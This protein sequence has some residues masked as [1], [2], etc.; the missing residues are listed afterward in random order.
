MSEQD[1]QDEPTLTNE[2]A[3]TMD[4]PPREDGDEEG[5]AFN[6]EEAPSPGMENPYPKPIMPLSDE[7]KAA[8][9]GWL[10]TELNALKQS[11]SQKQDQWTRQEKAYR[12]LPEGPQT[13]PFVGANGDVVPLVASGVDPVY[14]RL[15]TGIFKS[16][17]WFRIKPLKIK[18][19]DVGP[20]LEAWVN[21][22]ARHKLHL[23]KVV[24]PRLLE[25]VKHGTCVFKTIYDR[26][27]Y[28][29]RTYDKNWKPIK[30]VVTRYSGPRVF[31]VSLSDFLVPPG[32]QDL[33]DCHIVAERQRMTYGDLQIAEKSGKLA[34]CEALKGQEDARIQ[35][36]DEARAESAQH[37]DVVQASGRIEVFEVWCRYDINED[38]VPE[39]IVATFHEPTQTLLQLRYNWLFSQ[40]Y[41]YTMIP[42]GI[43]NDSLYGIGVSEMIE[44]FQATATQWQRHALNNAYLANI[45]MFIARK[46][47]GM[48]EQPKLYSG[49]VLFVDDPSRD[50]IPFRM[51][52]IYN[53]TISER[54]NLMGLAEK[55][56]GISDY[57]TGRE[58]PIVGS[59]ATATSTVALIQE[60]TRRVE[61]VMENVRNGLAEVIENCLYIWLQYGLDG[62]DEIVLGDDAMADDLREF[63]NSVDADDLAGA[64]S[65][66]L[67]AAD[68]A[69]NRS[70]QQQVKLSI[71][72]VWM[73]YAN[74]LVEA[75]QLA[76]SAAE[77]QPE[78]TA[79]ISEVMGAARRLFKDLLQTYEIRDAELY[80]PELEGFL[81]TTLERL[82]VAKATAEA[83]AQQQQEMQMQGD[84]NA[85]GGIPPEMQAALAGQMGPQPPQPP[86]P[87]QLGLV[88]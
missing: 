37:Q 2:V 24:A 69:N 27:Q 62:M 82:E 32:Y 16:D 36:L 12:A 72:Q 8:F 20:A 55:R 49:K 78:L 44:P 17:P 10:Q 73:Q 4:A 87:P 14:A 29:V 38:G 53:S 86:Q 3:Y 84:P 70:I 68:A 22:F 45:R 60:G 57:L 77:Q 19:N 1:Y 15:D 85:G 33:Q 63:F 25:L 74:K 6:E 13:I 48:E 21:F 83:N 88:P 66:T 31:G 67:V 50:V 65:I 75:G 7:K 43:T 42:Y 64:L 56:S 5:K 61:A 46:E 58:S 23:R 79:M 40:K 80:L 39:S 30:K 47:S 35:P 51:G 81:N 54:Q 52:D 18:L 71:I 34:N 41:P 76:L 28:P 59:R 26:E 11:H 9:V